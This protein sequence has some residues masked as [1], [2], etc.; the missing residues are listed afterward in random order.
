MKGKQGFSRH[1]TS[2]HPSLLLLPFPRSLTCPFLPLHHP[3]SFPLQLSQCNV[4]DVPSIAPDSARTLTSPPP[5]LLHHP[6][7][8]FFTHTLTLFHTPL[9]PFLPS[10]K[11]LLS[12]TLSFNVFL[13]LPRLLP[14]IVHLS[15]HSNIPLSLCLSLHCSSTAP[16]LPLSFPPSFISLHCSSIYPLLCLCLDHLLSDEV[17]VLWGAR[18]TWD[19]TQ[20]SSLC[21]IHTGTGRGSQRSHNET[22][23]SLR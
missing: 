19:I 10:T 7:I 17:F 21:C 12:F 6:V 2:V 9:S 13:C 23:M 15:V 20:A 4:N 11:H 18:I 1:S 3:P 5:L 16:A 14:V 8:S 22:L